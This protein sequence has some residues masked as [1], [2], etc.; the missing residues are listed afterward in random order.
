[1]ICGNLIM[2]RGT[3]NESENWGEYEF[4]ALPSPADRVMVVREDSENYATVLSVHHYPRT[5]GSSE[6]ARIEVVAKWTGS[7]ARLR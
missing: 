3:G 4:L 2:V 5:V 6:K 7:G 1:M